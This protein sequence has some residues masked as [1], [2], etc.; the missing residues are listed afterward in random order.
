MNNEKNSETWKKLYQ[1]SQ[2]LTKP[3][4]IDNI[5]SD[6]DVTF[7]KQELKNII[8]R[9]LDKGELH[10][11]IK[12]YINHALQNGIAE[13][14]AAN[15]SEEHETIEQWCMKLFGDQKF[16]VVFNSL[17]TFSNEFTERMCHIVAPLLQN[18]GMPLGGLSF[19]FFMGNYGFT[20]FGIHKE[21][22]GEEGFLFHLGPNHKDFY[23]WD[24]EEYNQ[25][26]H[27]TKVFHEV[28]TMLSSSTKY[29]LKAKSAMFIP[30]HVYHIAK[31]DEFS[32]SVVMDYINP[33]RDY[34]EKTIA[35][36]IASSEL[37]KN[38]KVGYL[39]PV[40]ITT[41]ELDWNSL[42]NPKTWEN[43]YKSTLTKYIT[44]LKSN[45][46]VLNPSIVENKEGLLNPPFQIMGKTIF[47]LLLHTENTEKTCIM[48]RGNEVVVS[49]NSQLSTII[50][51]LNTGE[52]ISFDELQNHLTSTWELMDVFDF[53]SQLA[54]V[55][56]IT[57][58]K[59]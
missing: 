43:K 30:H 53:V 15:R 26:E 14:M 9:F 1:N 45:A 56:A 55:G 36:Q 40:D 12:V 17:E 2:E 41:E 52:T 29:P 33:S 7:L 19:L 4:S 20:P 10:K 54:R 57:I 25:I 22:K 32:L 50:K 47:P 49:N 24:I 18:A 46:G 48:A 35:K 21:A 59:E 39:P 58:C 6:N 38:P 34:L 44:K 51:K 31:T 3:T 37:I 16:G 27:N 13:E 23:T 8:N 28:D 11:G 42:L 5:L